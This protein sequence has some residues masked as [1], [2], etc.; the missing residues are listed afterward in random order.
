MRKIV[1]VILPAFSLLVAAASTPSRSPLPGE[2]LP[3]E[4]I[5]QILNRL[6]FGA[7]PG[8]AERVRAMGV[9]KWIDSNCIPIASTT[10]PPSSSSANTPSS[11]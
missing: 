5:Q 6:T 10:T 2:L 4:Q 8:D 3:D 11:R 1:V 7:R 9:D